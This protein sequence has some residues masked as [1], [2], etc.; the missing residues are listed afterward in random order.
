MNIER[1]ILR[2]ISH[3]FKT[4]IEFIKSLFNQWKTKVLLGIWLIV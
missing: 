1:W 4:S 3:I 2:D